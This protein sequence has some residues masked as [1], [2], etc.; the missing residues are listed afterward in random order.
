MTMRAMLERKM[1]ALMS[2]TSLP[3]SYV[4]AFKFTDTY[5]MVLVIPSYVQA[6]LRFMTSLF[7][8]HDLQFLKQLNE[9]VSFTSMF[10]CF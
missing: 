3:T 7:M 8:S 1:L 6:L 5:I 10:R 2:K 9:S 4:R